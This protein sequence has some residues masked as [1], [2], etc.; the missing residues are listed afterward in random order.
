[1]ATTDGAQEL[2]LKNSHDRA[3]APWDRSLRLQDRNPNGW[4]KGQFF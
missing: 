4:G 2:V 1:M 3:C